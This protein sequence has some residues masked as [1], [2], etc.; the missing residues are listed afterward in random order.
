MCTGEHFLVLVGHDVGIEILRLTIWQLY[1][2]A[3]QSIMGFFGQVGQPFFQN[4]AHGAL[5]CGRQV[6]VSVLMHQK[7][8]FTV[9]RTQKT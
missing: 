7:V 4:G 9:C 5:L 6:Q 8:V 3:A 1:G 2:I